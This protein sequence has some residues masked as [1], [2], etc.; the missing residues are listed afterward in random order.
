[1]ALSFCLIVGDIYWHF[2]GAGG[3]FKEMTC[4]DEILKTHY[5]VLNVG[6]TVSEWGDL[7]FQSSVHYCRLYAS[8][9]I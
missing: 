9:R 1:M 3:T 7:N 6:H 5:V 4:I 2:I 8:E